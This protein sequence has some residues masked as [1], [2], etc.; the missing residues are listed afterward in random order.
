MPITRP[1]FAP[2]AGKETEYVGMMKAGKAAS[3]SAVKYEQLLSSGPLSSAGCWTGAVAIAGNTYEVEIDSGS[4]DLLIPGTNLPA[5]TGP[6][7]DTT[8]HTPMSSQTVTGAFADGSNWVGR[9]FADTVSI[10]SASLS[11]TSCPFLAMTDQDTNNPVATGQP[12]TSQGLL[13]IAYDS[14]SVF[15]D[16]G[17]VLSTM[18]AQGAVKHDAI[19]VRACQMNSGNAS[20]LDWGLELASQLVCASD[21]GIGAGSSDPLAIGVLGWAST[22]E[23]N[24]YSLDVTGVTINGVNMTLGSGW[25][26]VTSASG[27]GRVGARMYSI[28]DSCTTVMFLPQ[29]MHGALVEGI[30]ATNVFQGYGWSDADVNSFL[31]FQGAARLGSAFPY[32]KLPTIQFMLRSTSGGTVYLTVPASAYLQPDASG[33][34]YFPIVPTTDNR[35]IFGAV[36]FDTFYVV[37]D[38]AGQR[39]GFGTGCDCGK[40]GATVSNKAGSGGSAPSQ[41]QAHPGLINQSPSNSGSVSGRGRMPSTGI[42][43][44]S[45]L[46]TTAV[47]AFFY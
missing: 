2:P 11:A 28:I 1:G 45:V 18:V 41:P 38:R 15:G 19:G 6:T 24:F 31:N 46:V 10:P 44:L 12:G 47:C 4:S 17:T 21:V 29:M 13:G 20:V 43:A 16:G 14:L 22:P 33:H 42:T 5:Y 34:M 39:V 26:K 25:Q 23:E 35:I 3:S 8:T 7:Y 32:S 9:P 37:L 36:V 27:G 40:R 30:K